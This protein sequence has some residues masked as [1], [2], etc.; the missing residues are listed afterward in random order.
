MLQEACAAPVSPTCRAF[1]PSRYTKPQVDNLTH[2]A[3]GLFLSRAGLNRISPHA[4]PLLLLSANGPD[5][6][7][8][9]AAW[10]SLAYLNYHR[11]LTHSVLLLP[12][13]VLL[14]V[15]LLR[16]VFRRQVRWGVDLGIAAVGTLS[17]LALDWTNVYGIRLLLPASSEWF[18]GDLTSVVDPWIWG[19]C[20]LAV[21]APL[22]ARLV[23][24][25]IGGP[26]RPAGRGL[27]IFAL[28][29]VLLY[30]TGR[31]VLHRRAVEMLEAR[32]YNG[33]APLRVAAFPHMFNPFVWRGLVETPEAHYIY[34]VDVNQNFDP[35]GGEALLKPEAHTAIGI[36]GNS[37]V[38][39]D[40]LAFS[41]FPYWRVTPYPEPPGSVEVEA[42]DLR[43]S[44]ERDAGFVAT[45]VVDSVGRVVD[46]HFRFGSARPR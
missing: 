26:R 44:T 9:S 31:G 35:A 43:F 34:R 12:V 28:A 24:S 15:L 37:P 16:F 17:H 42:R 23:G 10:G 40:F 14:P 41:Q 3:V 8:V 13:M 1:Q 22:L 39:R 45:A 11:H 33:S 4:T 30:N 25:E 20:L 19:V 5:C 46:A 6:D 38:F 32:I 29:F 18:R 2:S 27:A 36:A 21:L 7:V